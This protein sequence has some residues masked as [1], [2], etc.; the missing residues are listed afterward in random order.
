[1]TTIN[2]VTA[3]DIARYFITCGIDSEEEG[4]SNLK[5]QKLVYYAQGYH[6]A[7]YDEPFFDEPIQAWRHGPVC[8]EVYQKY[9]SY[10]ARPITEPIDE[11]FTT[12]F[13]KVQLE[14]LDEV[15]SVFGQLAAGKLAVRTKEEGPWKNHEEWAEEIQKEEMSFNFKRRLNGYFDG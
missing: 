2:K 7:I 13:T 11:D 6:L 1:M 4:I 10:G 3:Y 12:T 8:P 15:Y 14:L 5:L 9:K